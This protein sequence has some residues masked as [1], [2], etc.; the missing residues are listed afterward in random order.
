MKD[1]SKTKSTSSQELQS[2]RENI[3]RLEHALRQTEDEVSILRRFVSI[4]NWTWEKETDTTFWSDAMYHIFGWDPQKPIP[5]FAETHS[6]FAPESWMKLEAALEA[7]VRTGESYEVDVEVVRPDGTRRWIISR[8]DGER[9]DSGRVF[10]L[11]G[12]CQDITERKQ[13]EIAL[14]ESEERYRSL[15]DSS[16]NLVYVHDFEGNFLDVNKP[17]LDL[18]GYTRDELGEIKFDTI[19]DTADREKAVQLIPEIIKAGYTKEPTLFNVKRKDGDSLQIEIQASLINREGKPFAIIGIGRD[20]TANRKVEEALRKSEAMYRSLFEN[21]V[22]GYAFCKMIF[23]DSKPVDFI[24]LDVNKSFEELTGLKNVVG[25]NVSDV[26]PGIQESDKALFEI[27]GRVSLSGK[28]ERFEFYVDALKDWYDLSVFSPRKEYFVTVFDVITKRKQS[29]EKVNRLNQAIE[30]SEEVI[31]MADRKGIITFINPA[32]TRLYGYDAEEVV[33]K[34]TLRILDSGMEREGLHEQFWQALLAKQMFRSEFVNRAKDGRLIPVEISANP[35]IDADG[36]VIGFLAVQRDITTRKQAEEQL[37]RLNTA[38]ETSGEVIFMTDREGVFTFVNESFT[39]LYGYQPEEVMGKTTPRILNSGLQSPEVYTKFWQSLVNKQIFKGEFVNRTKNGSLLNIEATAN[40]I[41]GADGEIIGFLAVQRD[42]TERKHSEQ[43][44]SEALSFNRTMVEASSI[45]IITFSDVG[46]VTS[47][48]SAAARITGGTQ[49][50]IEQQN[51]HQLQSWKDSG[52][53]AAAVRAMTTGES[54]LMETFIVTTYGRKVWLSCR[55]EPFT[56]GGK[57]QLLLFISDIS[58]RKRAEQRV[59]MQFDVARTL[60]ESRTKEAAI[61]G[62]L[63]SV[64]VTFGWE[65]G[66]YWLVDPAVNAL[67]CAQT[68]MAENMNAPEFIEMSRQMI[69]PPGIGLPGEIWTQRKTKW[70][71]SISNSPNRPLGT[72]AKQCG[73]QSEIGFP[74]IAGNEFLG[75]FLFCTSNNLEP[76]TDILQAFSTLGM[77][78]GE[79]IAHKRADENVKRNEKRYRTLFEESEDTI[80]VTSPGGKIVDVNPAGVKL[81]GYQSADEIPDFNIGK[82]LYWNPDDRKSFLRAIQQHRYVQNYE[83]E[84]KARDGRKITVLANAKAVYDHRDKLSAIRGTLRNVTAQRQL[85]QQFI[86]VQKLEG[87]GTLAG[88][89]AHDFNNILG[90]ILG[91]LGILE[92]GNPSPELLKNSIQV[93]NTAV[94][95]GT[96]LVKQILT[97]ARKTEIVRGPMD[98]NVMIKEFIKMIRET[99]PKTIT[100]DFDLDSQLPL[101]LADPT[102]FHQILLNICVNARDAMPQGGTLKIATEKIAGSSLQLPVHGAVADAYLHLSISDTGFGMTSEV[103]DHIFDPFF[104]TKEKGKG[105]GLGLATVYGIVKNHNGHID[106]ESEPGKGSV[107]HLYFPFP[108]KLDDVNLLQSP[109]INIQG[110]SETIF[111]IEDEELLVGLV[112]SL[113]EAHGYCVIVAMDGEEALAVYRD[114]REMIDLVLTDMDLPKISGQQLSAMIHEMN[115]DVKLIFASGFVEPEVKLAMFNNGAKSYVEKPYSP[116][117]ML[118]AIR[119]VLDAK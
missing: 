16:L 55:F 86:Q 69:Y 117:Q 60:S 107:F 17:A 18:F 21:M 8:G 46:D 115:P 45:G 95:R 7:T 44:V 9:D 91:Y 15:F 101:I 87:I 64:C 37:I 57:Q 84:L 111:L 38:V 42:I 10:R 39:R 3:S 36:N 74:I 71:R 93:M 104:T 89:I 34:K 22:E 28:P 56:Y 29:E 76:D 97:F 114:K 105:T 109:Q 113:L 48:N 40:S 12:T 1:V 90:I 11:R 13:A 103:R 112:K 6:F 96:N 49:E 100:V 79:Y 73:L 81:F 80:F 54:E 32:F 35:I 70:D 5:P 67:R 58:N 108:S 65:V 30:A 24:Y 51:F 26:I 27:Y 59:T 77:Q 25:R 50:Q 102:Q 82:D 72:I 75:V 62:I 63:K 92:S 43:V 47:I 20:V 116:A 53:Y 19:L 41:L 119:E 31:L 106:M 23:D 83:L 88:G 61:P 2:C 66:E 14:R 4:G 68:F 110:G 98:V 78:I 118:K 99:F 94:N 52:M 33:G 85:E